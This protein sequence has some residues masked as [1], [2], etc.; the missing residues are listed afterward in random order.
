MKKIILLFGMSLMVVG[1]YAQY[2]NSSDSKTNKEL[3]KEQKK[4]EEELITKSVERMVTNQ[5]F[6]LEVTYMS[7]SQD[8]AMKEV[9]SQ[10]NYL[11]INSDKII[12]Q[13]DTNNV[14]SSNWF[15]DN[16]PKRGTVTNYKLSKPEKSTEGY[17]I[18]F[19]TSGEFATEITMT[20]SLSGKTELI[21]RKQ[22]NSETLTFRGTL[23]PLDQ[24]RI[25]SSFL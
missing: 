21:V 12:L 11:A 16:L 25:S 5:E 3:K 7:N 4:A 23:I 2:E 1:T 18:Q 10:M 17:H 24:T 20:V 22:T 9:S 6:Y 19:Q 8:R 14:I 13:I 15:S